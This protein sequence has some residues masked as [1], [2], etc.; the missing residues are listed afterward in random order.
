MGAGLGGKDIHDAFELQGA[1]A[2]WE[3]YRFINFSIISNQGRPAFCTMCPE[4]LNEF[5]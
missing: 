4:I 5:L 1:M 2:G 3:G